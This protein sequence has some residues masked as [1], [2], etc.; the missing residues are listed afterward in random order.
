MYQTLIILLVTAVVTIITT[1]VTVRVTMTGRV[2]SQE[3]SGK[4]KTSASRIGIAVAP[5]LISA[6]SLSLLRAL[7]RSPEPITR[8]AIADIALLTCFVFA[9]VMTTLLAIGLLV[10]TRL[11]WFRPLLDDSD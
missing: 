8:R 10:V 3:A 6:W 5:L 1:I 4:L 9:N 11:R 2:L 7:V